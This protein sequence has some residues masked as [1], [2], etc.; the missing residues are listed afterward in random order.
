MAFKVER[1]IWFSRKLQGWT[2]YLSLVFFYTFHSLNF[3]VI[4]DLLYL[5]LWTKFMMWIQPFA[6]SQDKGLHTCR[7]GKAL[8]QRK[9]KTS[10]KADE[11]RLLISQRRKGRY[12]WN[13]PYSFSLA[14]SRWELVNYFFF[15]RFFLP[16]YR[17]F[18]YNFL[19]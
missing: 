18:I 3:P 11:A 5:F 1:L 15:T 13:V 8:R 10:S 9:Y 6:G 14:D 4:S 2:L 19:G 12:G 17:T 7:T 16:N